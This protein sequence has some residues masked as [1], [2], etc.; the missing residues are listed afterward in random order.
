MPAATKSQEDIID[1][2]P[3]PKG[4]G[5]VLRLA[6]LGGMAVLFAAAGFGAGWFYF[7]RVQSPVTEALRLIDRSDASSQTEPAAGSPQK[8][9]RQ[10]PETESFVTSYYTFDEPL[11]TNP[12]G[13]RRFLQ[14]GVTLST[15]Y[16]ASV[17]AHVETHK[18]A[19]RSDMLAVIGSFSEEQTT[20]RA[21][22][23][24][25]AGALRD[26]INERLV[27]LEGFGGVEGVFFTS[28]VLQ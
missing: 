15:Q 3:R 22:R 14:V 16:D 10:K 21:G 24:A 26:A 8:V 20:G 9:A 5:G 1:I 27:A 7:A 4:R 19:I 11:T 2:T 17:M 12:A 18:A 28:F 25:L 6:G 13:S 23:E